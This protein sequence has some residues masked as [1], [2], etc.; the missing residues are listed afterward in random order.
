M[1]AERR[2]WQSAIVAGATS[3]LCACLVSSTGRSPEKE[4]SNWLPY[5][6]AK[7][8]DSSCA[9]ILAG[10]RTSAES[11]HLHLRVGVDTDDQPTRVFQ[12][13]VV[14]ELLPFLTYRDTI[15]AGFAR[16]PDPRA[17]KSVSAPRPSRGV[18]PAKTIGGVYDA[19][20]S[21][22]LKRDGSVDSMRVEF[23]SQIPE[24]HHLL[25]RA[26][27]RADSAGV[28]P[29]VPEQL[30]APQRFAIRLVVREDPEPDQP[31][32]TV[33][34]VKFPMYTKDPTVSRMT[35]PPYPDRQRRQGNDGSVLTTFIIDTNGSVRRRSIRIL[36]ATDADFVVPVGR[37]LESGLFYP[38]EYRGCP[39]AV[40]MQLPF[41]FVVY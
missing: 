39:L 3:A 4:A 28:L 1:I 15:R 9:E 5:A 31:A 7:P 19:L 37:A 2:R 36:E 34:V 38:A 16:V 23:E 40:Q 24:L 14:Q 11:L 20:I 29:P 41:E 33:V 35:A 21:F 17:W 26:L 10:A 18:R 6:N 13:T 32:V 25:L 27:Q 8:A 12:R 30:S 22:Q